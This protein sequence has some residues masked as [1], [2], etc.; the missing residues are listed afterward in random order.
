MQADIQ[1]DNMKRLAVSNQLATKLQ[2][3]MKDVDAKNKAT[4]NL[5]K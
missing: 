1:D 5:V 2:E 3:H 4:K